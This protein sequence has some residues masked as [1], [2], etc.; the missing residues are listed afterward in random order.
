MPQY[1]VVDVEPLD[2]YHLRLTFEDG[3]SGVV[4]V[5]RRINFTSVFQPLSDPGY[6]RA[7][8]VNPETRTICWE[9][10]ADLDP[11]VLYCLATGLPIPGED[12]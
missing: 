10:G 8:R 7:V 3:T 6:F 9:N 4:D 12:N 2:G 1:D 5:A 11:V